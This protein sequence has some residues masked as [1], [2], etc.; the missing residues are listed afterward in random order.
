MDT[1]AAIGKGVSVAIVVCD[2]P[3]GIDMAKVVAG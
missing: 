2:Q 3:A 1:V